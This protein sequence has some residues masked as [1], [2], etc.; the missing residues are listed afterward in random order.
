MRSTTQ[1][2]LREI[3]AKVRQEGNDLQRQRGQSQ[4]SEEVKVP[5][6]NGEVK[7]TTFKASDSIRGSFTCANYKFETPNIFLLLGTCG[8]GKSYCCRYLIE[9]AIAQGSLSRKNSWVF[10]GSKSNGQYDFLPNVTS[11]YDSNILKAIWSKLVQKRNE[12]GDQMAPFFFVFD[13]IIG[14]IKTL[15]AKYAE[16]YKLLT[17][18]RHK[19]ISVFICLQYAKGSVCV[20]TVRDQIRYIFTWG[21]GSKLAKKSLYESY[22]DDYFD[23]EKNCTDALK[24]LIKDDVPGKRQFRCMLIDKTKQDARDAIRRFTAGK[25]DE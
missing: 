2:S 8:S 10:T 23:N 15:N 4:Q 21:G 18:Y 6:H 20:P 7:T 3:L 14:D 12:V 11:G 13:D 22:C 24:M 16:L 5:Q 1:L 17:G 9:Q 19:N 25:L